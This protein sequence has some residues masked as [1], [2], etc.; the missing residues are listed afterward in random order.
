MSLSRR[1]D[2]RRA[3]GQSNKHLHPFVPSDTF[4]ILSAEKTH[5]RS[6]SYFHLYASF[7]HFEDTEYCCEGAVY[8]IDRRL[9][10]GRQGP[11]LAQSLQCPCYELYD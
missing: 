8:Y 9:T 2:A 3:N 5:V 1:P 11:G 10:I 4:I 6:R 7:K